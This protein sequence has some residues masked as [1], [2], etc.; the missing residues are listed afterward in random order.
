MAIMSELNGLLLILKNCRIFLDQIVLTNSVQVSLS[1]TGYGL[2][3]LLEDNSNTGKSEG[4]C[5]L[6]W[7][8]SAVPD[9]TIS[10]R[11]RLEMC[12]L[13]TALFIY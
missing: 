5:S 1:D 4:E 10:V 7:L 9:F 12:Y 3:Q 13:F 11:L 2:S 8:L 6:L